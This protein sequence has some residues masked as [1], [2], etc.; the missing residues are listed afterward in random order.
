MSPNVLDT[1]YTFD[2]GGV[3]YSFTTSLGDILTKVP[4]G[5]WYLDFIKKQDIPDNLLIAN[6]FPPPPIP[7]FVEAQTA[8]PFALIQGQSM[9]VAMPTHGSI[10]NGSDGPWV[11]SNGQTL[12]IQIDG[13]YT[14]TITLTGLTDGAATP[15]QVARSIHEQIRKARAEVTGPRVTV[16]TKELGAEGSVQI[17]GGT[18]AVAMSWPTAKQSGDDGEETVTFEAA[19]AEVE[20]SASA[21]FGLTHG[22]TLDIKVD[23]GAT[24]VVTFGTDQFEDIANATAEEVS[25]AIS[26][27]LIGGGAAPT[28][29]GA[30]VKI[31]SGSYGTGSKIQ[32]TGGTANAV[33]GFSLLE[34]TG[35]GDF[36]KLGEATAVEVRDYLSTHL[37]NAE[38][39]LAAEGFRVRL[40]AVSSD[41]ISCSGEAAYT[42]AIAARAQITASGVEPYT[43][44]R[45]GQELRLKIDDGVEQ[46]IKMLSTPITDVQN[47][48]AE[49]VVDVL[50]DQLDGATA[51]VTSDGLG[52]IIR[53]DTET[54]DSSVQV[55][56]GSANLALAFP[57]T[58][59]EGAGIGT[60]NY[61]EGLH[62]EDIE[63]ELFD[64]GS[65]GWNRVRIWITTNFETFLVY[66]SSGVVDPGWTVD[67][68]Q[69][70]SPG[71][72]SDDTWTIKLSHVENFVSDERVFVRVLAENNA[73]ESLDETWFFDAED[74]KRP[75]ISK[76]VVSR[77]RKLRL[78]YNEPM[79]NGTGYDSAL[80]SADVSGRVS[81]HKTLDVG[82]TDY[83]N[84]I[85]APTAN[86]SQDAVGMFLGSW[87]AQNALNN[88]PFEIIQRLAQD[89][90]QVGANLVDE[91]PVD[92]K[93]YEPPT[94]VL[95]P[96]RIV[97]IDQGEDI[98][99]TAAPIVVSAETISL[100]AVPRGDERT[101]YVD[102]ELID[103]LT[104][105]VS[106]NLE[107]VKVSDEAGNEVGSVYPMASWQVKPVPNREWDLWELI[108]NFNKDKD[109]TRDLE[110]FIKTLD[111]SAQVLLND[112][113]VFGE[114]MDP[115]ATKDSVVDIMLES[116]GNP[117]QFVGGLDLDKKRDLIPLLVPMYKQK[118]VAKGIEDA[119][120]FF[121]G[122]TVV[123][124][125]W[126]YPE[127]T[128]TLGVSALGY[129]TYVGPS[130]SFVRYSFRIQH[131]ETLTDEDKSRIK[132]IV[133][134]IRPAHTH[135]VGYLQV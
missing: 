134:F 47:A 39:V 20:S 57:T 126:D 32:V 58:K 102:V 56:G 31:Y 94:L 84:V 66:D 132:E 21:P 46:T 43:D 98:V 110:R 135:F 113:D 122:K 115:L 72:G 127:D 107:I 41:R 35:S 28:E 111:E 97:R 62:D 25:E 121:V 69:W 55:T 71:S 112:V 105:G 19:A 80:F 18:A 3:T 59:A 10:E 27:A 93:K 119:V 12:Q 120:S 73:A 78:Q 26:S 130:K 48:P 86:F 70:A 109:A 91:A 128:W 124:V 65:T 8:E 76:I 16:T 83:T 114:L 13:G 54:T 7:A 4:V 6:R 68:M 129:N 64:A 118:G 1:S 123:V 81:Y 103:D 37:T 79:D 90:V 75:F 40:V 52:V 67:Q 92:P 11:V 22:M 96:Y 95:S 61:A 108:P 87:G 106:Y 38:A 74:T 45:D 117:L 14:Q 23:G 77:P 63:L 33:L 53:S 125:P 51:Y 82:G 17:V 15:E 85:V 89:T 99:P 24:Q 29:A 60:A 30:K 5:A 50:N 133:D 9:L 2:T 131:T 104:P 49:F 101:R 100:T 88:G 36:V 116:F 42:L 34:Q 44:L